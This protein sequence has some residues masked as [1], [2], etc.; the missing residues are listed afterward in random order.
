MPDRQLKFDF[1]TP[2]PQNRA[3]SAPE[4]SGLEMRRREWEQER[5]LLAQSLG[6]ALDCRVEVELKVGIVLRGV[7]RLAKDDLWMQPGTRQAK[8]RIEDAEFYFH[9]VV[10]CVR[11]E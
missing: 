5:L 3:D 4:S 7:L 1:S 9:E 11:L 2:L 8:L 6:L 10:T